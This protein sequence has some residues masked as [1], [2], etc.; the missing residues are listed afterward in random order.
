LSGGAT[1]RRTPLLIFIF[2]RIWDGRPAINNT[3]LQSI[4]TPTWPAR[5][6][7]ETSNGKGIFLALEIAATTAATTA[8]ATVTYTNSDGTGGRTGSLLIAPAASG[9]VQGNVFPIT[10]Q[11][12]DL[13]VRS[14]ESIQFGTAWATGT[15][16]LVAYRVV[17]IVDVGTK[18]SSKN[19][20]HLGFIRVFDDSCLY[21]VVPNLSSTFQITAQITEVHG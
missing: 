18:T 16:N 14:V 12:G 7:D 20:G 13:G 8:S 9:A 11:S 1:A 4:T 5:D 3:S 2:D 15:I 21:P 10:L 6:D 17:A 19:A